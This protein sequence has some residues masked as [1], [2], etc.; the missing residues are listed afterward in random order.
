MINCVLGSLLAGPHFF[1]CPVFEATNSVSS[2]GSGFACWVELR[3]VGRGGKPGPVTRTVVAFHHKDL[4]ALIYGAGQPA[5][6][7]RTCPRLVAGPPP[8]PPPLPQA[9]L[10]YPPPSLPRCSGRPP[11]A[12]PI[13]RR[14]SQQAPAN[15]RPAFAG[16]AK[17]LGE[18]Q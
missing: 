4:L 16:N 12:Q 17:P 11:S 9:M 5:V 14:R 1:L 6:P 3:G 8:W 2:V 7:E 10:L 13:R 15:P 18:K